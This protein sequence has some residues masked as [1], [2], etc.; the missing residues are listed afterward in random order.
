MDA[1]EDVW[2]CVRVYQLNGSVLEFHG[3]ESRWDITRGM[4]FKWTKQIGWYLGISNPQRIK[5]IRVA[6]T[7]FSNEGIPIFLNS[8]CKN[9]LV[10]GIDKIDLFLMCLSHLRP[11]SE[12]LWSVIICNYFCLLLQV[13]H[14]LCLTIFMYMGYISPLS[15]HYLS[16]LHYCKKGSNVDDQSQSPRS[17]PAQ[18]NLNSAESWP[19]T[20]IIHSCIS[21]I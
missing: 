17:S 8:P 13:Y 1:C 12:L 7:F 9:D 20:P 18:Y 2:V 15:F 14:Q 10:S 11:S 16:L 6:K 19:K 4:I 5:S 21:V 3:G